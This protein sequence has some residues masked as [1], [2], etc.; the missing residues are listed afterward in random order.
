MLP[1]LK[2][3]TFTLLYLEITFLAN[4]FQL[5]SP[6][7]FGNSLNT[8][9]ILEK[10]NPYLSRKCY[11]GVIENWTSLL[12]IIVIVSLRSGGKGKRNKIEDCYV[13]F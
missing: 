7:I 5:F 13:V 2:N 9:D 11:S 1:Y 4:L 3:H 8:I 10:I 6:L 12:K